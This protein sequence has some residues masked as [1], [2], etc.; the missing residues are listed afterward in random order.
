MFQLLTVHQAKLWWL[1]HSWHPF[2]YDVLF[3][4]LILLGFQ[5]LRVSC[6]PLLF[7]ALAF[8][9]SAKKLPAYEEAYPEAAQHYGGSVT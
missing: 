8:T 5:W 9:G 6:S 7:P 2:I 3:T 4:T 1:T